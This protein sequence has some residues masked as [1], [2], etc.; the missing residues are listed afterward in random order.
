MGKQGSREVDLLSTSIADY[1]TFKLR[2]FLTSGLP[3]FLSLEP[4]N[5]LFERLRVEEI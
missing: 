5:P 3:D 1:K 2:N 4:L